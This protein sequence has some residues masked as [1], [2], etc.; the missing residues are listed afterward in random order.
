M[1]VLLKDNTTLCR[2]TRQLISTSSLQHGRP[3]EIKPETTIFTQRVKMD[4]ILQDP[5]LCSK[6]LLEFWC[7]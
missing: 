2:V 4:D 6:G 5:E 3:A 7:I 1:F